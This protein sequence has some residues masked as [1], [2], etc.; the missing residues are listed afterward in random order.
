MKQV[1]VQKKHASKRSLHLLIGIVVILAILAATFLPIP[2]YLEVPGT[3]EKLNDIVTVDSKNDTAKGSFMLTTVGLQQATLSSA[4]VGHFQPFVD[5]VPKD[6]LMGDTSSAEYDQI[7][8]YYMTSSQNAAIQVALDLAGKPYT[9]AFKGIYVMSIQPNSKFSKE[10]AV[11][12][13]VN[14][15]DGRAFQTTEDFMEYVQ[16]HKVGDKLTVGFTH[17]GKQ[18]T[19]TA[20]LIRLSNGK[21]GIGITLT[22]STEI[23]SEVPIK[24]NAGDIGGPSAGLMFTLETYELLSGK[25]LRQ[26]RQIAGTGTISSDGKVGDIG[27]I[28]KKVVAADAAGA[29]IFFAPNNPL[30]KEEKKAD[31]T[32]K[33]NYATAKAAAEKIGS[34][35]KIVPV[36]K[37]QDALDYLEKTE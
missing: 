31:P 16:K 37:V 18:K 25:D 14:T 2:Y 26:G 33:T 29:V 23:E 9:M 7:Q 8:K 17:D 4:I 15:V 3:A 28:D 10:L 12:D 22:D 32:A 30:S 27:G 20:P 6:E 36:K 24:I 19:A 13:V 35:M 1:P 34:K 11:G 5:V 21:V